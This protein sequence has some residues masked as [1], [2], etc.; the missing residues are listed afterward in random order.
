V[1]DDFRFAL[2]PDGQHVSVWSQ[3]TL[4]VLPTAGGEPRELLKVE[5]ESSAGFS[6][7]ALSTVVWTPDSRHLLFLE[8]L[9]GGAG[10][11]LWRISADG[12]Q[13]ERV[14][15]LFSHPH[16][17]VYRLWGDA[18]GGS[19][20][21]S[22]HRVGIHRPLRLHPDG[23]Q[24][25]F[26]KHRW[27]PLG[28][29][30][31]LQIVLSDEMAK[32]MCAANLRRIGKAI[33][34][35]K[36]DHDDVPDG[37]ADLFPD[38]LQDSSVLVCPADRSGGK[39]LARAAD[40]N[41]RCS[42]AYMFGPGTQ[43]VNG[44]NVALPVDFP[45]REGMTWKDAR[46][47]QLE[48]Y[49]GMVPIVRCPHHSPRMFLGYN[50][51]IYEAEDEWEVAPR[52]GAGLLNQLKATMKTEPDTWAQR[53]DMQ[54]FLRLL[55]YAEGDEAALAKLLETHLKEHPEDETAKKFLAELPKLRF[56]GRWEDDAEE[57]VDDGSVDGWGSYLELIHDAD[58]GNDEDQ[59]VGIR[60]Q[61]IPV[62]QGARIKRAYVQFTAH[63]ED[64]SS[65]KTDLVLHAELAANADSFKNVLHNITSRRKT[66]ASVKW[67]PE[68]WTV[69]G[70]RSEKQCTPDLSL[71]IQEVVDQ[72]DW[73]EGNALV[74]IISG[75][76]R[77]NAQSREGAWSGTP[78]LYVEH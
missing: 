72:P 19:G 28:R 39:P 24:M 40:P 44:Y 41:M 27:H 17:R 12:G 67:S 42:Y 69:P 66:A 55:T 6:G 1:F 8:I 20:F 30:R 51:D 22:T 2:S 62:P 47:L 70:E 50:G 68:P 14:G 18:C 26:H 46:K 49:G 21:P 29:I 5:K 35:Y 10:V 13:P 45:A 73:Q 53:Y 64:P 77:R 4:K 9:G 76:G 54:R 43:A 36:S 74:L 65:E 34:Q 15:H 75:S 56:I 3:N 78:M 37:F 63:P 31:M 33:Q 59:V 32:E 57:D 61:D 16:T 60:F 11:E 38:Y 52:A 23:R 71:L 48:Y 58:P 7:T 25:V